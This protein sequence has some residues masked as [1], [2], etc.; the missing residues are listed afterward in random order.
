RRRTD[1]AV[2]FARSLG[3]A[4]RLDHFGKEMGSIAR[5]IEGDA[6]GA[7][8]I[9]SAISAHQ[10]F[11]STD[12][13]LACRRIAIPF[14]LVAESVQEFGDDL[15]VGGIHGARWKLTNGM[16]GLVKFVPFPTRKSRQPIRSRVRENL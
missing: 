8:L 5:F 3:G 10:G 2:S 9:R 11:Q 12:E 4:A 16:S 14:G 15:V 1:G 13:H 7:A 6:D